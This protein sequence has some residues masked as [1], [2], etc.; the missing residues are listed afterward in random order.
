M[1]KQDVKTIAM[2][3]L[4]AAVYAAL[5]IGLAPISYG[6][7][8]M[9]IS[10]IMIFLAFYNKKYIPG[11]VIGC[12]IANV[13]SSLGFYDMIFG[14]MATLIAVITI[15]RISNR[16]LGG[17]LGGIINGFIVGIELTLVFKTPLIMNVIYVFIGE[18]IILEIG[19]FLF[20]LL[21]KNKALMKFIK[22]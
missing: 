5:T 19:A 21:E 22:I 18:T 4:I 17:I 12:F 15:N 8:Q 20:G 14:T 16:Y 13:P 10:E 2:N 9:R 6:Q 11:L 1:K 7:I 3:A